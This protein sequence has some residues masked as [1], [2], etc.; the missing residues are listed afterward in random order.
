MKLLLLV[1]AL[2]AVVLARIEDD[3][4]NMVNENRIPKGPTFNSVCS[5]CEELVKRVS[6]LRLSV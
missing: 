1:V 4:T 6:T 2:F 5:E 3:K